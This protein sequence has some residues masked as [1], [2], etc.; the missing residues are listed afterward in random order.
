MKILFITSTYLGDAII[1]TGILESLRQKYPNAQ[2]TIAGGRVPLPLFEAFPQLERL[3]PIDKEPYGRHWLKLWKTCA[4]TLW[5]KVI[6]IRGTALSYALLTKKRHIWKGNSGHGL[7]VHQ[8]AQWMGL[9]E[10]PPAKIH[11]SQKNRE[12][13]DHWVKNQEII[14]LSPTA[15]WDKKSWPLPA[16]VDLSKKLLDQN[17]KAKIAVLG[18]PHQR[19]DLAPLF[20]G[21]PNG[22]M[23]DWVGK[24]DLPTLAAILEK[25]T[26]F[27][28]NDSGLMHLSAAMGT[29][30]LGLFG[31]SDDRIYGPWGPRAHL[32]RT[33]LSY[34][35]AFEKAKEGINPMETLTVE[36]V[37]AHIKKTKALP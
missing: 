26:L 8:L 36:T 3:I 33:P 21:L 7:K 4:L 1:T 16:F 24:M 18:A 34:Q 5:D 25:S 28:G 22:Q 32:V 19:K 2:F 12:E 35:D 37:L 27:V 17:P 31:P 15:N 30:T 29:P 10:T 13:A 11:L 9:K 14:C 23:L 6:D 20:K